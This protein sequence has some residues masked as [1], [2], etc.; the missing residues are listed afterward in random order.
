MGK[1]V[2]MADISGKCDQQT[3]GKMDQ[4][5]TTSSKLAKFPTS[6]FRWKYQSTYDNKTGT[7]MVKF[8]KYYESGK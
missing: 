6:T 5:V 7:A 3:Y 8:H 4:M 2:Y 1:E